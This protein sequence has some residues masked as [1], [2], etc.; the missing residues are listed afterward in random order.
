MQEFLHIALSFPT[1]IWT[2]LLVLSS[3]YWLFVMFGAI[4]L[5][6]LDMQLDLDFDFDVDVDVDLAPGALT[7]VTGGDVGIFAR[8]ANAVGIGKVPLTV[9]LSLFA[10]VGWTF[11]FFATL[12]VPLASD[13]IVTRSLVMA[14]AIAVAIPVMGILA[15]PLKGMMTVTTQREGA[16]LVGQ[17]CVIT[18]GSVT[19]TFGQARVATSG[20]GLL[21]AVRCDTPNALKRNDNALII[22]YDEQSRTYAI[23]P[24]EQFLNHTTEEQNTAHVAA[25]P[26]FID[27][28]QEV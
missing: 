28:K 27:T 17:T 8:V 3:G 7:A 25:E 5:E 9:L 20:A 11:S 16:E 24:Y 14:I 15:H 2:I 21:L 4:D 6:F 22:G 12:Y 23:E 26:Q 19:A 10:L 18:T 13:G 1:I